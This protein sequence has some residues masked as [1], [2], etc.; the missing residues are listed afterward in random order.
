MPYFMNTFRTPKPGKVADV[1]DLVQKSIEDLG[2]P[3]IV[4]VAVSPPTPHL[5][6]F[7]VTAALNIENS[8]GV[9]ALIDRIFDDALTVMRDR[10]DISELCTHEAISFSRVMASSANIPDN[11]TPKFINRTFIPVKLGKL[12]EMLDLQSSWHAEIDHPFAYNISVPIGGP[13]SSVRVTHIVE[14]FTS[15]EALN[16]KIFSDPRMNNLRDMITGSGVR[17]LGRITYAKRA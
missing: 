11:F 15:L 13:V 14:S 8:E 7:K 10:T 16:E 17:S 4:S 1:A 12:P 2:V 5:E 9:D 3:G 6:S